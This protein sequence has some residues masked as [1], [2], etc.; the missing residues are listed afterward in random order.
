MEV[1]IIDESEKERL[2]QECLEEAIGELRDAGLR[3]TSGNYICVPKKRWYNLWHNATGEAEFNQYD[4][5]WFVMKVFD[6]KDI[7]KYKKILEKS[8]FRWRIRVY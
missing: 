2:E 8:K 4:L 1:E 7:D 5:G 6:R 3:V